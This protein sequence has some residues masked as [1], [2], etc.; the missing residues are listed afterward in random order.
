MKNL[1]RWVLLK[2]DLNSDRWHTTSSANAYFKGM[3]SISRTLSIILFVFCLNVQSQ[4]QS[5]NPEKDLL[6]AQFDCKT[7]VD[8]L[9]TVAALVTLLNHNRFKNINY[10]AVTGAYGVQD[11]L[12]VPPNPLFEAAFDNNWSDAHIDFDKAL[13]RVLTKVLVSIDKGGIIWV[14]DGGQ[15]DF[16]AKW[17]KS[18]QKIRP[19]LVIKDKV[20]VVQHSG[21]NE[22]VTRADLLAYVKETV[23]YHK[24]S[25]GNAVGNGTLGFRQDEPIPWENYI[26]DSHLKSVWNLAIDLANEYNGKDGRYLNESIKKGGL[27]FS[28]LSE[29]CWILGLRDLK[30]SNTFFELV[31]N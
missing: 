21:W 7:D 3:K 18:L 30:D 31:K 10:H 17:V 27:D 11:G 13:N 28:D 19:R 12:Y 26:T 1:N 24:I 8:D 5:F 29:T 6:L 16:T 23:S 4:D 14:A 22:E 2:R 15:S 25:D 9:H 20:H